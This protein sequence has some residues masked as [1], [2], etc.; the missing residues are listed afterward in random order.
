MKAYHNKGKSVR[1]QLE[2]AGF[3]RIEKIVDWNRLNARNKTVS[4]R[5]KSVIYIDNE[6]TPQG[7]RCFECGGIKLLSEFEADERKDGECLD[8]CEECRH[9]FSENHPQSKA[10]K[11]KELV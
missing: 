9:M 3:T 4:K 8:V 2:E 10:I 5:V 7:K 1:I 6:G 11:R